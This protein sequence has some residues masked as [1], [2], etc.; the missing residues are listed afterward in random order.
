MKIASYTDLR[1]HMKTYL[2]GV[3]SDC[4]PLIVNR[5]KNKGVVII[6]LDEYNAIKETEY[7]M[8]SPAMT[9]R[10]RNAENHLKEGKGREYSLDEL[11][12]K[13]GL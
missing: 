7:I 3:I 2:D 12:E 4:E 9:E 6:S 10:L 8:R 11:K 13:M 5:S 1:N